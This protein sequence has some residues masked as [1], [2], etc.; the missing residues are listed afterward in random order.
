MVEALPPEELG[1]VGEDLF[2]SLCSR[3]RLNCNKSE[4]DRT[5]WDFRVEFKMDGDAGA[6]LDQRSPRAA[7]IQLKCTAGESGTRV[8]ADYD[9]K[10]FELVGVL[11]DPAN[12]FLA[13][14]DVASG[15]LPTLMP[16]L[17]RI[18]VDIDWRNGSQSLSK[19]LGRGLEALSFQVVERNRHVVD[20]V[21]GV[22]LR[23]P[24]P[25]EDT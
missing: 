21:P 6:T 18:G 11:K 22:R 4:R 7:Q 17:L 20:V 12:W 14:P 13:E 25:M 9:G 19:A 16:L 1:D 24:K 10:T 5:G 2:R 3:A 15:M 8:Q 23:A